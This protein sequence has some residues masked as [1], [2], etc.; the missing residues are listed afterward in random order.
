M[1]LEVGHR[2]AL[3]KI[4]DYLL[5]YTTHQKPD[6]YSYIDHSVWRFIMQISSDFFSTTAHSKYLEGLKATGISIDR[7]PLVYE[8]DEKLKKIGWRAVAVSGFIPPAVFLEFM[9]LGIM[10]IACEIRK[11]ENIAYT[12]VP[13]IVHEAAGHAPVIADDDYNEYVRAYGEVAVKAI[14]SKKDMDL[15][16]AIKGLSD[17]KEKPS[18]TQEQIDAAQK[19][20]EK[21]A[22]SV[23]YVSEAT[24]LSRMA[25][26]TIEYG[27]VGDPNQ[28]K[29]YG[30]GLL[31]SMGESYH[32]FDKKVL[33]VPLTV[34]CVHMAFDITRPQPQLFVA[35]SFESAREVLETYAKTMAYRIG[36]IQGLS[37]ARVAE[38]TTTT[39]LDC[40]LQI[41]G[42]V[43]NFGVKGDTE[44]TFI[45]LE[46]PLQFCEKDK[47]IP[48]FEMNKLPKKIKV[49]LGTNS[50]QDLKIEKEIALS[51]GKKVILAKQNDEH[52]LAT[53]STK[54]TSVY[55]GPADRAVY[56]ASTWD[57]QYASNEHVAN[58]Q[59]SQK[60]LNELFQKVR[61]VRDN[62]KAL[63]ELD[64]VLASLQKNFPKDWLLRFE[65]IEL[66]LKRNEKAT[67][68]KPLLNELKELRKLDASHMEL[69]DRGLNYLAKHTPLKVW[70]DS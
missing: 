64:S 67:Y 49:L 63:Q 20:F 8:I 61:D 22:A 70:E 62:K 4:P 35:T 44:I 32:S 5:P 2:T 10:P 43:S 3:T 7:I 57:G 6:M 25:W 19:H 69:I 55:G 45:E 42:T 53:A 48:G 66:A 58:L 36:G 65:L 33:K 51:N 46:G 34:D 18:S 31:S 59:G 24:H 27:L 60:E 40:G 47:E 30:A 26:W 16:E 21:T 38:T 39:V 68:F 11:L 14:F 41:S 28:F 54:I 13:D 56:I 15:Y 17:I 29:L 37:K 9:S 23:D 12:P 52:V 50:T 1:S